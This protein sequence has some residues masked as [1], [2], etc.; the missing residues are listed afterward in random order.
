MGQ[1]LEASDGAGAEMVTQRSDRRKNPKRLDIH[2]I[3]LSP[4]V[5]TPQSTTHLRQCFHVLPTS[6]KGRASTLFKAD[7]LAINKVLRAVQP[8]LVHGWGNED[9]FGLAAVLSGYPCMVSV[10]GLLSE[11]MLRNRLP[12]RTYLQAAIEL[13]VVNR[14]DRLVCESLWALERTKARLLR[15]TKPV[16]HIEYGVQEAFYEAEWR[17]GKNLPAA[18]FA[19]SPDP[20]KGIQD[21]VEAFA[22]P[23]LAKTEL[24]VLGSH[25]TPYAKRLQSGATSNIRWFGRLPIREA[26]DQLRR[27][28]CFVLPTR[29]DTGPMALKEARVVGLPAISSPNSGACDYIR[30]GENGFLVRPGDVSLLA[31]RLVYLLEDFQRCCRMGTVRHTEARQEFHPVRTAECF[32]QTYN[33]WI[34]PSPTQMP[35]ADG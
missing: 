16:L 33:A 6:L 2:W 18:V 7:R 29:A 27:A 25:D 24:W 31:D 19:G 5:K 8:D 34:T 3:T 20:R 1:I 4:A 32:L 9:V 22:D 17:P 26:L 30:E 23:R 21:A 15:K 28:W 10:Q 13:F 35:A 11:Y 14:A 12:L